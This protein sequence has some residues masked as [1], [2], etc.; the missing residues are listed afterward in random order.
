MAFVGY[1]KIELR[2]RDK[3][4]EGIAKA[5]L[6]GQDWVVT[7]KIDGANVSVWFDA[8]G[9]HRLARRN[10]FLEPTESFFRIRDVIPAHIP[11]LRAVHEAVSAGVGAGSDGT[12]IFGELFGG[13][14]PPLK[15][16]GAVI[17]RVAYSP[18]QLFVAFD[19]AVRRAAPPAEGDEEE[20]EFAGFEFLP[21]AD[22]RAH[23]VAAGVPFVE[24]L[25]VGPYDAALAFS[26][27]HRD[28]PSGVW[29]LLPHGADSV[30]EPVEGVQREGHV[31]RP[32]AEGRVRGQRAIVKD[33]SPL[34][35]EE[36]APTA[37]P[38][39]AAGGAPPLFAAGTAAAAAWGRVEAGL[40]LSRALG[41]R[42]KMGAVTPADFAKLTAALA[43]DAIADA[44]KAMRDADEPEPAAADLAKVRQAAV[45]AG[46]AVVRANLKN[47]I[48][49]A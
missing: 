45:K 22:A 20:C 31:I 36:M 47:I 44:L 27:L 32:A 48:D 8:D 11:T 5:G 46:S 24:P 34:F 26:A 25:F 3:F 21:F 1:P 10:G 6:H 41:V 9:T 40:T 30:P 38:K 35:A 15:G 12:V 7:E 18:R 39:K 43:D 19:V 33:K 4:M 23:C 13:W 17:N 29:R 42:S 14:Y 28:T 2:S 37:A 16:D 49:A